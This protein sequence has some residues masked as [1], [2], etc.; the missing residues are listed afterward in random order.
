MSSKGKVS[1]K[2]VSYTHTDNMSIF[3]VLVFSSCPFILLDIYLYDFLYMYM[4][5]LQSVDLKG[6]EVLGQC[7]I[8]VV[9]LT[10]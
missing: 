4:Y 10:E 8:H 2:I 9:N 1:Y 3:H 6:C 5:V 7:Y